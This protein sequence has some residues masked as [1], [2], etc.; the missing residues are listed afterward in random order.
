MTE[1]RLDDK[2]LDRKGNRSDII[3]PYAHI[4]T[5]VYI[6]ATG[7]FLV[8]ESKLLDRSDG[9][10]DFREMLGFDDFRFI[11]LS[12]VMFPLPPRPVTS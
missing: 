8:V 1:D 4:T 5:H 10:D 7:D 2:N 6:E 9:A 3:P 12:A 11:D